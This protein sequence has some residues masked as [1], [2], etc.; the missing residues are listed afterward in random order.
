MHS[1]LRAVGFSQYTK[2][3]QLEDVWKDIIEHP[4]KKTIAESDDGT[5]V[6]LEKYYGE[7]FGICICGQ[8]DENDQ[9]D[10]DYYYPFGNGYIVSTPEKPMIERHISRESFC[11][12]CD[13]IR[14]GIAVIF[15]VNN[16]A[17]FK[18]FQNNPYDKRR[19]KGVTLSGLAT[20]GKILFPISKTA[21]QKKAEEEAKEM[22]R[23]LLTEARKG[24]EIAIQNLTIADMES[25]SM[26][27]KRIGK[28][29]ILTIVETHFMPRGIESDQYS[30]L[31]II[32]DWR[33]E[34][35][36]LTKEE[37]YVITVNCNEIVYD[38]YINRE[39]LLGEPEVGRRF[40]ADMWLQ[41]TVNLA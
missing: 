14:V 26:V 18:Q 9:F 3:R 10:M 23:H 5:F 1:Y 36:S 31:G 8:L 35:N 11:G 39:D 40:K 15:Y 21:S 38:V 7:E 30:I 24:N 19:F 28:E 16:A 22:R 6:Q 33:L 17:D 27:G 2:K 12:M 41:G 20:N 25:Y 34:V 32:D 37:V 13:D 29:D 4:D